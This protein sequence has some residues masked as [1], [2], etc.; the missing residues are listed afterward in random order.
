M[1]DRIRKNE[2]R[3]DEITES[4]Q[5]LDN[6]LDKFKEQKTNIKEL[7]KYYESKTWLKDYDSY[8]PKEFKN[9]KA[10]V[11]SEDAIWNMNEAVNEA[12]YKMERIVGERSE[13]R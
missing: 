12:F 5:E 3:L 1:F 10:G 9:V 4:I 8:N 2:K 11:L 6:A 7:N 13:Y